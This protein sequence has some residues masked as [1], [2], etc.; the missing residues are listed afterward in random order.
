MLHNC[1]IC[2]RFI[3][4]P[5]T[6]QPPPPLPSM[7]V[8][9]APPFTHVGVDFAGTLYIKDAKKV[10]ICLYTCC[11]TRAVHL[12]VVPNMTMEAFINCFRLFTARRGFPSR[13]LSN[14]GKTFKSAHRVLLNLLAQPTVTKYF[15]DT[16]IKW[17]FNLERAR[18]WG[19]IFEQ[20]VKSMK[21]C[22]KRTVG[23]AKLTSDELLTVV[24]EV[25]A[26][27]NS[28]PLSYILTEDLEEPLTPSHL[29]VGRRLCSY[30]DPFFEVNYQDL[31][32]EVTTDDL[33]RRI[34]YF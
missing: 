23:S 22:L 20:L 13:V 15:L 29:L 10:W 33:T 16:S 6:T 3:S 26:T 19:G 32:Y 8:Q 12:E 24:T 27:L 9:D 5:Y 28:R 30:P 21:Q 2:K 34:R 4:R 18:W 7:R 17:I 31:K 14:N 25:E 11:A 1:S